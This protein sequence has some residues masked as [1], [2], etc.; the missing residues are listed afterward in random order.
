MTTNETS[1]ALYLAHEAFLI[2][3]CCHQWSLPVSIR[4]NAVLLFFM[5]PPVVLLSLCLVLGWPG[6]A[7]AAS[8]ADSWNSVLFLMPP[9]LHVRSIVWLLQKLKATCGFVL[10]C[11]IS[12][13]IRT[14]GEH[15]TRWLA[16]SFSTEM[17]VQRGRI[18]F[19]LQWNFPRAF[20]AGTWFILSNKTNYILLLTYMW[21]I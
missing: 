5:Y 10:T 9:Y 8:H 21:P 16:T 20:S 18:R 19:S 7:D 17:N 13:L 2:L 12:S 4:M 3:A 15:F 1:C 14:T 11:A 6:E